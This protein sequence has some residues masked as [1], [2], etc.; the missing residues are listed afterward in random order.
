M[1]RIWNNPITRGFRRSVSMKI[2]LGVTILQL[3]TCSAFALS[4]YMVNT[5]QTDRLLEQFDLRLATDIHV[6]DEAVASIPG[7]IEEIDGVKHPYYQQVKK[8]L[9]ALKQKHGLENV[10]ILANRQD[11]EQILILTGLDED[12]G[13]DY[14]FTGEMKESLQKGVEVLS[15]IYK[16]EYGIH[17]SIFLPLKDKQGKAAGILGIDLDASVV[18]GTS[19]T[20][21]WITATITVLVL[22]IG[23]GV[24]FLISRLITKPIR[25]LMQASEQMAGGDL[26]VDIAVNQ[27]DE[28]GKLASS[29][30]RLGHNLQSLVKQISSASEHI[31][32]TSSQLVLTAGES[33]AGSQQVASSMSAMNDSIAEVVASITDSAD[34]IVII[35]RELEKTAAGM[36]EMEEEA[37][38]VGVRS[39]HGQQVVEE[40][41]QQMSAIQSTMQQSHQAAQ[42]LEKRSGEISAIIQMIT[43]IS[44][45]TNLLA[46]NAAIEAARVGEA[47]RGFAVVAEEVRKL[48]DQSS[49]AAV[50]IAQLVSRTQGDCVQVMER[51]TEGSQAVTEGHE[52]MK[53]T[54]SSFQEIYQG[55]QQFVE[56]TDEMLDA[57]RGVK[58]S[59]GT[60]TVGMRRISDTTADQAAGT[61]QV[62]A[63]AQEQSA[64]A[65]EISAAIQALAKMANELKA[66]VHQFKV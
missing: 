12:F 1:N 33:S 19:R 58:G 9:E 21:F 32:S 2:M 52:R 66:S 44:Q 23:F 16:D 51:I 5:K 43:E 60:I 18:P 29:F 17:K 30:S 61:E 39:S 45:Q 31:A 49:Q 14:P 47:G 15:P 56:Q 37:K 7:H 11:K 20:V 55:I 59:F 62:T 42:Q 57:V 65:Q 40:T 24:T 26:T 13:T 46:L 48:A 10:Y 22:V 6:A 8:S 53:V 36:L 41:L 50:S 35:D 63:V 4:G 25:R 64:S 27:E 34:S 54:Y 28:I 38:R 3:L